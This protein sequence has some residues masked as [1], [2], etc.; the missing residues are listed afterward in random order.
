MEC[1]HTDRLS[2]TPLPTTRHVFVKHGYPW[3]QQS[4]NMAKISKSYILTLPHPQGRGMAVKCEEPIDEPTVPVWLLYHH[5]KLSIF[6]D[7]ITDKQTDRQ[8]DGRSNY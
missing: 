5:P 7:G 8:T 1:G 4:H 2:D 6:W 3:R